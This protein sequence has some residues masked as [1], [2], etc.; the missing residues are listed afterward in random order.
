M[1]YEMTKSA[2]E[3]GVTLALQDMGLLKESQMDPIVSKGI[4]QRRT[5]ATAEGNRYAKGWS[6]NVAKTRTEKAMAAPSGIGGGRP[7]LPPVNYSQ[8]ASQPSR[9]VQQIKQQGAGT[10]K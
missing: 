4:Q 7:R 6:P 3:I 8:M 2:Y 10:R 9:Y 1:S 5:S